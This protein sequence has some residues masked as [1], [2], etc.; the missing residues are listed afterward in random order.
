MMIW[1]KESRAIGGIL[2]QKS[3]FDV[4]VGIQIELT[5][6][7][8]INMIRIQK[9]PF[10]YSKQ[11]VKDVAMIYSLLMPYFTILFTN[12]WLFF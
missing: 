10:K 7:M 1:Q 6:P 12:A 2:K 8:F 3:L 9:N 11:T 5:H 4:K